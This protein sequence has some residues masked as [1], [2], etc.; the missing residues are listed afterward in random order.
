VSLAV[1][2]LHVRP[3]AA[4][5]A[6]RRRWP[7]RRRP[8][9]AVRIGCGLV[10]L[11]AASVAAHEAHPTVV[12]VNLFRLINQLP[13]PVGPPLLGV[14]QLGALGA[15]PVLAVLV[16]LAGRRRLAMVVGL[17]GLAAWLAAKLVQYLVDEDPP[18]VRLSHV[19][20]RDASR[21]GLAFPA[22]HVAVA[23]ALA[24]AVAPYV[25]RS[26]RRL[27]WTIVVLVAV[28]RIYVGLHMPID[29]IGG[30]ALGWTIG[31]AL[32]LAAGVPARG[33]GDGQFRELVEEFGC[34]GRTV[35][36]KTIDQSRPDQDWLYRLWRMVAFREVGQTN[37]PTSTDHRID[38]EAHL[39]LLAERGGVRV[40]ALVG[41][42]LVGEQI[43]VIV[44]RWIDA[45]PLSAVPVDELDDGILADAWQQL[46]LLHVAGIAHRSLRPEHVLLDRVGQTWMVGWGSA[47]ATLDPAEQDA[48]VAELTVTLASRVGP[49][50][51]VASAVGALG[52]DRVAATLGHLQPLALATP[53]RQ[54][55]TATPGLLD[56]IRAEVAALTGQEPASPSRL[57]VSNLAP[58][59][60]I[61]IAVYVL[62]PRLAQSSG[63]L[64][65]LSAGRVP[66]LFAVAAAS[67]ATYLMAAVAL[68]AAAPTPLALGRTFAV[69][70]A[71][72]C[73]NRITPAGLGAAATNVRYLE[74]TGLDRPGAAAVVAVTATSG[75]AVHSAGMAAVALVLG[76]GGPAIRIPDLDP[77]WPGLLIGASVVAVIGWAVWV[78]RLYRPVLPWVHS[79]AQGVNELVRSPARALLLLGASAGLTLAYVL[80]LDA[81]LVAFGVHLGFPA[82][83]AVYLGGSAVGAIAPTPGG[84]GPFEAALVAGLSAYGVAAGPAVAAVIAFRLITYWLP[85]APG[86]LCLH[87]LRRSGA[88]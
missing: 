40:P 68:C 41:T 67:S 71:A 61:A 47:E 72:T 35:I 80:A 50:R 65:Q 11:V 77:A 43:G 64:S 60:A 15:V 62:L 75:L 38:R 18:Q 44:R 69:Q 39:C 6:S 86:A 28:A 23:A 32:S 26:A 78:K 70:L 1:E 79:A 21:P 46:D 31:A 81:A 36:V 84:V 37:L 5:R 4:G 27:A 52:A 17:T 30:L 34:D 3:P 20:L 54:L 53:T 83:A 55:A 51:A 22:S 56:G 74:L 33:L 29:V 8:G 48:D 45:V 24:T 88:L 12:E 63:G 49:D 19:L 66:W 76:R 13:T 85:V 82:L 14:M 9:D 73:A 58:V 59:F 42:Q 7:T 25:R 16:L 57:A 2:G 10:L 87:L